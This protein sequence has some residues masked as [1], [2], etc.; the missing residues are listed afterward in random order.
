[1]SVF[2]GSNSFE[3]WH[4]TPSSTFS[5][6]IKCEPAID[7]NT[8]QDNQCMDTKGMHSGDSLK[9]TNIINRIFAEF[10]IWVHIT[11]SSVFSY[12]ACNCHRT[13]LMCTK[14]ALCNAYCCVL[15]TLMW[16]ILCPLLV[17]TNQQTSE[18]RH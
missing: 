14:K 15:V 11:L 16:C 18:V 6:M 7:F 12:A 8:R 10:G 13:H 4:L 17:L 5:R 2:G 9:T 3:G 1:M